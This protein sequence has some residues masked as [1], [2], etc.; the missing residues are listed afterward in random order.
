[1]RLKSFQENGVTYWLL[2]CSCP[3]ELERGE[4]SP[5]LSWKHLDNDCL[6]DVYLGDNACFKCAKCGRSSHV[7]NWKYICPS[8]ANSLVALVTESNSFATSGS[9]GV[10][11][12]VSMSGAVGT[13]LDSA[14]HI[15]MP[16]G[17]VWL[18][19]FLANIGE[20]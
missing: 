9:E 19:K 3:V 20:W 2:F 7:K 12:A 6:G 13:N 8:H 18:Q 16:S 17:T 1:M 11:A 4:Y 15:M 5:R 14:D 10:V